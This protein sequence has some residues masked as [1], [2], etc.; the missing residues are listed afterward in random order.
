MKALAT[1]PVCG[2]KLETTNVD[3]IE[4]GKSYHKC[5]RF[6]EMVNVHWTVLP[7]D[8]PDFEDIDKRMQ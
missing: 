1:C 5:L 2:I 3:E 4:Q 6:W 7:D 8:Y